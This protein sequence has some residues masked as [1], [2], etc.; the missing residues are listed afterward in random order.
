MRKFLEAHDGLSAILVDKSKYDGIWISSLTHS[1]TKGLPDNELIDIRERA[2]LLQEIK[3]VS[4]KPILVDIDSGG[5]TE[6]LENYIKCLAPFSWG[7]VMEDKKGTKQNSLL[8]ENSQ[9]LED[10]DA[11]C[12]KIK[13]SKDTAR[14]L[15][16]FARIESLIAKKS[17][18][19][20]LI[21][22]EAYLKAGADGIVIHSKQKVECTE[23]MDFAKKFRNQFG[24]ARYLVAIPTTYKLPE[25]HPFDITIDANHLLRA[26]LNG[27]KKFL[28]GNGN[29]SS[30]DEIFE[31]VG[32]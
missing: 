2:K 8:E 9:E 15:L 16:F 18:Y 25:D 31:L 20:A 11:F 22:A 13:I 23:V 30:V 19:D 5:K 1:A 6:H 10:V 27:M 14:D 7:V 32:K 26:S 29:L 17:I 28:E 3:Q 4:N 21:R 12:Q 24:G